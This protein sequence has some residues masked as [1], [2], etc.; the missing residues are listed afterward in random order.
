MGVEFYPCAGCNEVW[1]DCGDFF[2]CSTCESTFCSEE[3]GGRQ[4][5]KAGEKRWQDETTCVLCRRDRATDGDLL[6]FLLRK[7]NLTREEVFE[8]YKKEE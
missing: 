3:C 6:Y 5:I 8:L 2:S 4:V 1:C 7:Y